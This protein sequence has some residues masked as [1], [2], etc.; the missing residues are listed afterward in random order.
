VQN[1]QVVVAGDRVEASLGAFAVATG[2]PP[3]V[4]SGSVSALEHRVA[5]EGSGKGS[6]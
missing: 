4:L 6:A 2:F 1:Y 3:D 5:S